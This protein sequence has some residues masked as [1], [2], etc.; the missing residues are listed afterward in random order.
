MAFD[1]RPCEG[2]Q[3]DQGA[4]ARRFR[5]NLEALLVL[6]E[7]LRLKPYRCTAGRLTIGVGRNLDDRGITRQEAFC[8]LRN[9]LAQV[10]LHLAAEYPDFFPALQGAR[11]AAIIDLAFNLGIAPGPDKFGDFRR[12]LAAVR[13][14]DWAKAAQQLKGSKWYSQVGVRGPRI[15]A[16]IESGAWPFET[17]SGA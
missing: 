14:N 7:G 5:Q 2:A 17:A 8:L 3:I 15:C 10:E 11:R 13:A 16:M 12:F 6:N 4:E 1:D 9:D